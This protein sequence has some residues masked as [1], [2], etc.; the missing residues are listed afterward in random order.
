MVSNLVTLKWQWYYTRGLSFYFSLLVHINRLSIAYERIEK[1]S[2]G[3]A[4]SCAN[5]TYTIVT[6]M[7]KLFYYLRYNLVI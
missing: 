1:A 5:K 4:V 2:A 7:Y 6:K 3:M